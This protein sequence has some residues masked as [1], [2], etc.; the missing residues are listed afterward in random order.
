[1]VSHTEGECRNALDILISR[2]SL[3]ILRFAFIGA[4][5]IEHDKCQ[6]L[7]CIRDVAFD[8]PL[9]THVKIYPRPNMLFC[10]IERKIMFPFQFLYCY[11]AH[12]PTYHICI[13]RL[14]IAWISLHIYV[15][16]TL[17]TDIQPASQ[18]HTLSCRARMLFSLDF[19]CM[20]FLSFFISF[21]LV[22][23]SALL[24]QLNSFIFSDWQFN[25]VSLRL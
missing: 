17:C 13:R 20:R 22:S 25:Y 5:K 16:C 8:L 23:L 7:I 2:W 21:I 1:M 10:S 3:S 18:P 9:A 6:A 11:A 12:I 24:A 19:V 14:F 15:R 4:L